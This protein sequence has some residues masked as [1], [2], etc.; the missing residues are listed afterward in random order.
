LWPVIDKGAIQGYSKMTT[1][2]TLTPTNK[3]TA[4]QPLSQWGTYLFTQV[5]TELVFHLHKNYRVKSKEFGNLLA[6]LCIGESTA[7]DTQRITNLHLIYY[8]QDNTFM[9]NLKHDPKTMLLYTKN[10][11]KDKTNLD[12]LIQTSKKNKV[13]IATP[14]CHYET[15]CAPTTDHQQPTVLVSHFDKRTYNTETNVCVG[16]R[17]TISN[18]NILPEIG[19][20]NGAICTFS[21]IV[22]NNRWIRPN[23]KEHCH[24]PDYVV[25]DFPNLKLLADMPPWDQYHKAVS[26]KL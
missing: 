14:R 8:E 20:Y 9:T 18:V 1:T 11:D 26:L 13:L 21:K 7:K 4:A 2:A 22:Y 3:Q 10:D 6:R 25:V 12:M 16:A 19:L 15:N 23:D 17:V 5:M 24:L